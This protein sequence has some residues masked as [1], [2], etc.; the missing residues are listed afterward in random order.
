MTPS[1][2]TIRRL[3]TWGSSVPSACGGG[4]VRCPSQ[5]CLF[6]RLL[7]GLWNVRGQFIQISCVIN[8]LWALYCLNLVS[9]KDKLVTT[10]KAV[11][12]ARKVLVRGFS[13]VGR[14]EGIIKYVR[15]VADR[16]G[17]GEG[18]G[19]GDVVGGTYPHMDMVTPLEKKYFS[20][21]CFR[22][23]G[24]RVSTRGGPLRTVIVISGS[25]RGDNY[26]ISTGENHPMRGLR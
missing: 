4:G 5:L 12:T 1:P 7:R 2:T 26:G 17:E 11:D 16:L 20:F 22:N 14:D 23:F 9:H 13:R 25:C 6:A 19:R 10:K 24:L 3:G 18:G 15:D 21:F 8:Y